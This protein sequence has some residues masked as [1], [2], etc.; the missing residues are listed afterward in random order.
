MT[1]RE[2]GDRSI[3]LVG[4]GSISPY[5]MGGGLLL[6]IAQPKALMVLCSI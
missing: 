3:S 6:A 1:P 4:E 2:R 5:S